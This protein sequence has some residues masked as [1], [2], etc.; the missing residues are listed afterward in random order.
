MNERKYCMNEN[1]S[2]F[3]MMQDVGISAETEICQYMRLDYLQSL[4][5]TSE[6]HVKRR[7]VFVDKR[8]KALPNRLRFIPT[9]CESTGLSSSQRKLQDSLTSSIGYYEK[10]FA[11][12]LTSCWTERISENALMWDRDGEKHKACIVSTIGNFVAAL[13]NT[14]FTIWCGKMIYEPLYPVLLSEDI[15]WYKEPYY[16]DEK[17]IRFYFSSDYN[18][19][20][21]DNSKID[22]MQ[23][24]VNLKDLIHKIILSPY[25]DKHEA[26]E[27]KHN[28]ESIYRISTTLSAIEINEKDCYN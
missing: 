1:E 26:N 23:L 17:E 11:Q 14:D 22:H 5:E 8:E 2:F 10:E 3:K 18:K 19:V 7:N 21:P 6:Y 25:I 15:V 24:K 9:P 20:K 13:G 4:L 16:S 28:I 12:L 27:I